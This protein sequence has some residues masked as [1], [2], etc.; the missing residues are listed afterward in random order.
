MVLLFVYYIGDRPY[1]P[2]SVPVDI[3]PDQLLVLIRALLA[4]DEDQDEDEVKDRP[5]KFYLESEEII[6]TLDETI[7][8]L[9]VN[10]E[11]T[12]P[13]IFKPQAIFR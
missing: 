9:L 13:I 3:K 5:F 11:R 7:Q 1:P 10:K 8:K 2:L 6:Q 4:Q 12:V